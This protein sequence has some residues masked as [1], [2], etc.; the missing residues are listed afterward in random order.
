VGDADL[1]QNV[2]IGDAATNTA[3]AE[4]DK[5]WR[6]VLQSMKPPAT[7]PEWETNQPSKAAI[8]EFEKRNATLAA[9][10]A[11]RLKEFYARYPKHEMAGEAKDRELYLLGVAVQLGNTNAVARLNALEE[12]KLKDPNLSEE[13]VLQLR[14]G[15]LQRSVL[16]H[17]EGET[18]TSLTA[19]EKGARALM[20]EFPKRQE[21]SGLL[22]SVAQGWLDHGQPD[23]AKKLAQELVESKP[24]EEILGAAQGLLKKINRVGQPLAIKF[25]AIDGREVDLAAFKGKVVL[26]DF[27][28][29]WCGPCMAELPK[30]KAAYARLKPKGFEIIGISLDRE[31]EA[32]DTVLAREEMT[33]PQYLDNGD[34]TKF[35]EEFEIESIPTMWLVDKKGNLRELNAREGMAEKVEKLLAE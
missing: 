11:G 34:G 35:A 3:L 28:A 31:K 22:M 5:A 8:A 16:A 23:T 25:K 15:Q 19:L 10:A 17:G 21:L 9:E 13:E 33:W 24:G 26:I 27:W 30:V 4:G 1:L 12:A 7:P 29:T 6:E 14:V 32:L 2:P 20:K 18:A